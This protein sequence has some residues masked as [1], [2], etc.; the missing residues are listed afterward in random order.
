MTLL[1]LTHTVSGK[2]LNHFAIICKLFLS[3]QLQNFYNVI[4]RNIK[5]IN[6]NELNH[7]LSEKLQATPIFLDIDSQV[8]FSSNVLLDILNTLA[9]LTEKQ[10]Q[11]CPSFSWYSTD[12]KH[13]KKL[14]PK[15]E[16][17][18]KI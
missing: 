18:E 3:F 17:V 11:L 6:L 8:N 10:T 13:T 2:S 16:K 5:S 12:L 9:P 4:Y 14:C 15:L 7:L 1:Q